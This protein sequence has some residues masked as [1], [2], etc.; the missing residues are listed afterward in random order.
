M[1]LDELAQI[2]HPHP[3]HYGCCA[4]DESGVQMEIHATTKKRFAKKH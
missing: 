2:E 4:V 1:V 3:F